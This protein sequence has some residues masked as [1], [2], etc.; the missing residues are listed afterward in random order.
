MSVVYSLAPIT[1]SQRGGTGWNPERFR[2]PIGR[3]ARCF[4]HRSRQ[5]FEEQIIAV[6]GRDGRATGLDLLPQT[7]YVGQALPG[8]TGL[9]AGWQQ[10][11]EKP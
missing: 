8:L 10:A 5:V 1:S 2:N 7:G 6:T 4:G 3:P 11:E 9:N